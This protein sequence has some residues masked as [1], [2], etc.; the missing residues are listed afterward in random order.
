MRRIA[1][2]LL[3]GFLIAGAACEEENAATDT[4]SDD[5]RGQVFV[6]TPTSELDAY[7]QKLGILRQT[8]SAFAR[9]P[10]TNPATGGRFPTPEDLPSWLEFYRGYV[11]Q[12]TTV[13]VGLV[14]DLSEL[15]PP[16]EVEDEHEILLGTLEALFDA[17]YRFLDDLS[18]VES[19]EEL[20]AVVERFGN[21]RLTEI[22]VCALLQDIALE[23]KLDVYL[24][25]DAIR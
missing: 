10:L 21:A 4:Q 3:L 9:R 25:C 7:F 16:A 23:N 2:L 5:S 14:A 19:D 15:D 6:R 24:E 17:D 18:R 13:R 12:L 11:P 1:L 22:R 8:A 20:E